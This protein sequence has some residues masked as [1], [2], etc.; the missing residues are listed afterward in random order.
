MRTRWCLCWAQH[1]W[2]CSTAERKRILLDKE[3]AQNGLGVAS[4][5]DF[6]GGK[7]VWFVLTPF[8]SYF[9]GSRAPS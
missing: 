3:A 2:Y 6:L 7:S 1:V 4:A 9:A 5:L 8:R